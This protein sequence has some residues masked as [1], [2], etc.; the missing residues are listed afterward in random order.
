[1]LLP[2]PRCS[3]FPRKSPPTLLIIIYISTTNLQ[4]NRITNRFLDQLATIIHTRSRQRLAAILT[5]PPS[6]KSKA[7]RTKVCFSRQ[8]GSSAKVSKDQ[9]CFA[10]AASVARPL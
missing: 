3:F 9:R 5:P 8:M 4:S 7:C 10:V 1:L 2:W 6:E